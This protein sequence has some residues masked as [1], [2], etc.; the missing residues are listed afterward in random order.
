[1]GDRALIIFKDNQNV[2]PTV[3]LHWSGDS[4]PAF[5]EELSLLME[6]R[7]N[8]AT[9]AAARFVGI[10]HVSNPGCLSLGIFET[11]GTIQVAARDDDDDTLAAYSH[12][13]AGVILVDTSDFSWQAFGGY[14]ADR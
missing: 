10:A 12:G 3:Y 14:L 4:V 2:S 1:M 11:P 8:D 6:N 9:Y 7:H 5:I 13:D